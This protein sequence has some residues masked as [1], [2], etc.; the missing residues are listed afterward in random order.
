MIL[1][2]SIS[3]TEICRETLV[4]ETGFGKTDITTEA[5]GNIRANRDENLF[6]VSASRGCR[7]CPTLLSDLISPLICM[8]QVNVS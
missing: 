4:L 3:V 5:D 1:R 7:L 2:K 6:P 8:E